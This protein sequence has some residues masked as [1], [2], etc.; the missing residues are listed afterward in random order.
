MAVILSCIG[1]YAYFVVA[2]CV[3]VKLDERRKTMRARADAA[4]QRLQQAAEET[5]R[6]LHETE[7]RWRS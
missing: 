6:A 3:L 5:N 1:A 7:R 2:W 4:C